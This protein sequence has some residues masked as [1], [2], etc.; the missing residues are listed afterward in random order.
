M[1]WKQLRM[2]PNEEPNCLEGRSCET[3]E[4]VQFVQHMTL[5]ETKRAIFPRKIVW[6]VLVPPVI[7]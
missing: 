5:C 3:N 7:Y 1:R 4:L 2:S 6:K